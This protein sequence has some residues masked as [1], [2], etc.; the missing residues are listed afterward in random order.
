[1]I[2]WAP[3]LGFGLSYDTTGSLVGGF[4][5]MAAF[6]MIGLACIATVD[7]EVRSPRQVLD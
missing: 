6:M 2:G 7:M 3:L 1:M 4:F 5:I